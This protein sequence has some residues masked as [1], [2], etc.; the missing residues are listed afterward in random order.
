MRGVAGASPVFMTSTRTSRAS[1]VA[2]TTPVTSKRG[3]AA[4]PGAVR[5]RKART[6]RVARPPSARGDEGDPGLLERAVQLGPLLAVR[7][8]DLDGGGLFR[9]LLHG[10]EPAGPFG[11]DA[12]L[13]VAR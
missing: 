5:T 12:E 2:T 7:G 13:E 4:R 3:A 11:H 1:S 6:R 8:E 10:R 9:I